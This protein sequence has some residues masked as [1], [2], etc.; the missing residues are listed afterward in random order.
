MVD[1][2]D[3]T[4]WFAKMRDEYQIDLWKLGYDRAM[5]GYWAEEMSSVFGSSVMEKV[6]QGPFT[7]SAPMK[8]MGAML[9]DKVINYGN[10]PITKWCL[11]NTGVK[12]TGSL[13]TIQPVKIQQKRR[14]DGTVSMLNAY[15][16]YVKYREDYL[17]TVG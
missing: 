7:W 9:S 10:N 17:N 4:A 6:A 8:E 3:V 5:A 1:F 16:I 2:H 11:S 13:D 15:T 12:I 14:I